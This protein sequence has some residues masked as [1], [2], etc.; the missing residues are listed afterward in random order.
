MI[1]EQRHLILALSLFAFPCHLS[2]KD[3]G[4]LY[5]E[6]TPALAMFVAQ[7]NFAVDKCVSHEYIQDTKGAE[8]LLK[9][10]NGG[11][12]LRKYKKDDDAFPANLATFTDYYNSAWGSSTQESREQFCKGLS[13]DILTKNQGF[14]RWVNTIE[15]FRTKFSPITEESANRARKIAGVLSVVGTA[16]T[17]AASISASTDSVSSAKA[18]DWATSNQQMAASNYFNQAGAAFSSSAP[19]AITAGSSPLWSVLE[20]GDGQIVRCPVVDHFFSFSAPSDNL[21]WSTYQS[22]TIICRDPL[23]TDRIRH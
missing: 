8:R 9:H 19:S 6:P 4:R 12:Q 11:I 10:F 23:P 7:V 16:A 15:Y 20:E 18:G 13:A 1:L 17:T 5:G 3:L 21:I 22:V 2:A 14:F